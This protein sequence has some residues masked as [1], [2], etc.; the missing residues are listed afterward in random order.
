[1]CNRAAA[2]K[3]QVDTSRHQLPT[4]ESQRTEG[5]TSLL[6][7]ASRKQDA[8]AHALFVRNEWLGEALHRLV[9]PVGNADADA[10]HKLTRHTEK[11]EDPSVS[12]T[13]RIDQ[14]RAFAPAADDTAGAHGAMVGEYWPTTPA[15]KLKA[16]RLSP[17]G[18]PTA[19]R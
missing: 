5:A 16:P 3:N 14:F 7:I 15:P 10:T 1:M 19:T 2:L 17:Q 8:E 9:D 13:G 12:Q 18:L 11:K 6:G 4:R